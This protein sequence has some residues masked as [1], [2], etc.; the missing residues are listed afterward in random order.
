M[1]QGTTVKGCHFHRKELKKPNLLF[2]SQGGFKLE[3][4]NNINPE[5]AIQK[6]KH[7]EMEGMRLK[8]AGCSHFIIIIVCSKELLPSHCWEKYTVGKS[9]TDVQILRFSG[10]IYKVK[11]F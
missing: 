3:K 7:R 1:L 6:P 11:V 10:H 2:R 9:N 4:G 5:Q 8:N